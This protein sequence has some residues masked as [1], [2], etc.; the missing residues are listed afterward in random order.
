MRWPCHLEAS[1]PIQPSLVISIQSMLLAFFIH[2]M[3]F[4]PCLS[5]TGSKEIL[6]VCVKKIAGVDS[7][8]RA[9]M[10]WTDLL[11]CA[12]QSLALPVEAFSAC[13]PGMGVGSPCTAPLGPLLDQCSLSICCMPGAVSH[14]EAQRMWEAEGLVGGRE[15]WKVLEQ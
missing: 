5:N 15:L 8:I 1:Q 12:L 14:G 6:C 3:E 2:L 13:P 10:I 9:G 4:V 7:S 11:P